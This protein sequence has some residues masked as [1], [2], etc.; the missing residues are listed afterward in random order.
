MKLPQT[1]QYS[2]A[3]TDSI[4]DCSYYGPTFGG[5]HDFT[6]TTTRHPVAVTMP[7]LAILT[8]HRAGTTTEA[9]SPRH[10]W[11]EEVI[12]ILHQTKWKHFTKQP[13][14]CGIVFSFKLESQI[15]LH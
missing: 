13:K 4:Y 9:P 14:N 8:A 5:G 12:I 11:Q 1:G 6:L 2:Y 15:I 10:F 7:T 3:N